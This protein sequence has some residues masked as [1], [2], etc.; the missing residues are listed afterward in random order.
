MVRQQSRVAAVLLIAAPFV[1]FGLAASIAL[2]ERPLVFRSSGLSR[3][4]A[5]ELGQ[6]IYPALNAVELIL[7]MTLV[8]VAAQERATLRATWR[9]ALGATAILLVQVLVVGP[10]LR[11]ATA[12]QIV[13]AGDTR[14]GW[15]IL[16]SAL[17]LTKLGLLLATGS[18]AVLGLARPVVVLRPA[19]VP[20]VRRLR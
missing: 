14:Y 10:I 16:F 3:T 18:T 4:Q 20:V 19:E 12:E 2:I 9:L 1:W 13:A 7:A 8:V 17:E 6:L 11:A 5:L 15:L